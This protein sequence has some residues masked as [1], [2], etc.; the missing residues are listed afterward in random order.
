MSKQKEY[1]I[2]E[3]KY[4]AFS[5]KN[6]KDAGLGFAKHLVLLVYVLLFVYLMCLVVG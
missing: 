5:R 6:L 1:S 2:S 4:M 3:L